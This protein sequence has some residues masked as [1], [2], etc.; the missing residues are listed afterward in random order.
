[1]EK[2]CISL[3]IRDIFTHAGNLFTSTP[4]KYLGIGRQGTC[5]LLLQENI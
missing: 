1:M 2:L 3:V 5:S 4:G